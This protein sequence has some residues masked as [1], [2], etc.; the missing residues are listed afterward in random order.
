M[1][2]EQKRSFQSGQT[3]QVPVASLRLPRFTCV[4]VVGVVAV[5]MA[6]QEGDD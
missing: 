6:P 1:G 4:A 3:S 2:D 5:A